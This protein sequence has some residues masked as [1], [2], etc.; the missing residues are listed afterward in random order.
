MS[1]NGDRARLMAMTK[2]LVAKWKDT[3]EYWK[4]SK[5]LEFEKKFMESLLF[6]IEKTDGVSE[7]LDAIVKKAR[8]DCE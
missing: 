3:R 6:R 7:K 1:L 8:K 5:S 4:D 2:E